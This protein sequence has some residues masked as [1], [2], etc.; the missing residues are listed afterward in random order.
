MNVI[1][2]QTP[3]VFSKLTL[4]QNGKKHNCN[5]CDYKATHRGSLRTHRKS[6]HEGL[7]YNCDQCYYRATQKGSPKTHIDS[8]HKGTKKRVGYQLD[9]SDLKDT[10][11][12]RL[13]KCYTKG[14]KFNWNQCD[15]KTFCISSLKL[16]TVSEHLGIKPN[17][18]E[19]DFKAGSARSLKFHR[20]SQHAG[21]KYD[22]YQCDYKSLFNESLKTH[23]M[24]KAS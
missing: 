16:H 4:N 1:T 7:R 24:V 18:N 21:I 11:N 23:K 13:T 12:N 3:K 9:S 15:Y 17:C 19:C 5:K 20:A 22:C 8:Q 6:H 10:R 2:E 14:I